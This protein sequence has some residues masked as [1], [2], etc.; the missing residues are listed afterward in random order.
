MIAKDANDATL[1]AV[2]NAAWFKRP[3]ITFTDTSG[4]WHTE[5][6]NG[7]VETSGLRLIRPHAIF[8]PDGSYYSQW[9]P[10]G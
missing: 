9:F 7:F 3:Y 10:G 4:N 6:F 2:Q 5:R 1:R 8:M